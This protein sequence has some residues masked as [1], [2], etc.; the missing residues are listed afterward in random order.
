MDCPTLDFIAQYSLLKQK[1]ATAA[2][3]A[4]RLLK[5]EAEGYKTDATE[6]IDPED[7]PKNIMLRGFR[8][9]NYDRNSA[10]ALEKREKYRCAYAFMYGHDPE[11]H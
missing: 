3:D 11:I 1:L 10:E 4:L 9:K 2:T 7:T 8:R 6:L 5:L